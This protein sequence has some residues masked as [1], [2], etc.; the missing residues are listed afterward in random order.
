[1]YSQGLDFLLKQFASTLS[2]FPV[3]LGPGIIFEML[4]TDMHRA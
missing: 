2:Q 4:T 3:T 1:M